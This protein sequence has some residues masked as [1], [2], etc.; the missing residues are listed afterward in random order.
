MAPLE[1]VTRAEIL[2][3][4]E[5]EYPLTPILQ[6]NLSNLLSQL[7][8]LRRRYGKPMIVSSGYRPGKY[9]VQ[10]GGAP[11]SAHL[12]C[13]ACDF[14]DPRRELRDY[15]LANPEILDLCELYMEDPR[16]TPTWVHLQTRPTPSGNRVFIP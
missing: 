6:R 7:N 10:A 5:G 9:N 3:G 4:R 13:E 2:M 12:T 16:R 1:F 11:R 8:V 14:H 15:I